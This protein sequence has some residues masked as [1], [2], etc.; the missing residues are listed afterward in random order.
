VTPLVRTEIVDRWGDGVA[1][2]LDAVSRRLTTSELRA[3]NA[4]VVEHMRPPSAV[5]AHWLAVE[6]LS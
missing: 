3:M 1:R 4:Q 6:G 2:T 5:A